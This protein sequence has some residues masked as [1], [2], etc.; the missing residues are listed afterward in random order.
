MIVAA[1]DVA[2]TLVS[3]AEQSTRRLCHIIPASLRWVAPTAPSPQSTAA[4]ASQQG[5]ASSR[6]VEQ[7][8]LQ[9]VLDG[10]EAQATGIHA[11]DCQG[12]TC[13]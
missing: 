7:A 12:K 11:D 3:I 9:Q 5:R 2:V 13:S 8:D 4:T 6:Q 10:D 1:A